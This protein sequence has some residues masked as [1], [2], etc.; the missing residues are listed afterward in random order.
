MENKNLNPLPI[1]KGAII[2]TTILAVALINQLL[3][4][5]GYSPLPVDDANIE[6]WLSTGFTAVAATVTWWKNNAITHKARQAEKLAEQRGL[7]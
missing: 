2:R 3:V 4:S 5:A 1:D 6:L 7:K